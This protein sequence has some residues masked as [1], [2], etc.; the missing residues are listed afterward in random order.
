LPHAEVHAVIPR[1]VRVVTL[2]TLSPEKG[3]RV[4]AECAADARARALPLSF[5][6]LGP[7]TERLPQ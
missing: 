4:V 2:G 7:T 3:L 6:I 5:R 1:V